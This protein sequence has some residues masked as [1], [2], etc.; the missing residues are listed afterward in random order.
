M[1]VCLSKGLGAP[2]GSVLGRVAP[3]ASPRRGYGA[4]GTAAACG[5]SASWRPPGATRW[6]TTSPASPTTTRGPSDLA[7][8]L[9]IDPSTVDS[10]IVVLTV[11]D[12]PEVAGKARAAGVLV[13]ALGPRLLR[14]VTHLDV[15]DDGIE[16]AVEVLMPLVR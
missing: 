13:S 15:D 16:R 1:S 12:A 11:P 2:V 7:G 3:T 10:N 8:A 9:G 14:L 4:S 6:P 5:R